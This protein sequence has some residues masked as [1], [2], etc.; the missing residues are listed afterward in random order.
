MQGPGACE[1]GEAITIG[2]AQQAA[3]PNDAS[4]L[5]RLSVIEARLSCILRGPQF[6]QLPWII[7][8]LC[9][10]NRGRVWHCYGAPS[11]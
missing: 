8:P 10:R 6:G 11:S 3:Q 9:N 2:K 4:R 5:P 1:A 7:L